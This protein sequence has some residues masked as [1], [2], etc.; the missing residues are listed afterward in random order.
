M[1]CV[2]NLDKKLHRLIL[3]TNYCFAAYILPSLDSVNGIC[4][5]SIPLKFTESETEATAKVSGEALLS[6]LR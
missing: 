3:K 5:K 6:L 4:D 1:H 2:V